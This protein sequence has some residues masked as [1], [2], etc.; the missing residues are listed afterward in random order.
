MLSSFSI[1]LAICLITPVA[2]RVSDAT[3]RELSWLYF[4]SSLTTRA[5][6][7]LSCV[8]AS[9]RC[10]LYCQQYLITLAANLFL[11]ERGLGALVDFPK[12]MVFMCLYLNL[13]NCGCC[14]LFSGVQCSFGSDFCYR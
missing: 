7:W 6:S 8:A 13:F 11:F 4:P 2:I 1:L 3:I 10:F 14:R 5:M 12:K 9:F